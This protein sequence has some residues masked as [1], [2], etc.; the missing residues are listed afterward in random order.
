MDLEIEFRLTHFQLGIVL[1]SLKGGLKLAF[2][3]RSKPQKGLQ[4]CQ[5]DVIINERQE[6]AVNQQASNP[7]LVGKHKI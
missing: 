6:I 3:F 4:P 2:S 5:I 1:L 7:V